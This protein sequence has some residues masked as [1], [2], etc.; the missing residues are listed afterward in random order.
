MCLFDYA[1][2]VGIIVPEIDAIEAKALGAGYNVI[3]MQNNRL[4]IRHL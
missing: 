4:I 3:L 1:F 2:S